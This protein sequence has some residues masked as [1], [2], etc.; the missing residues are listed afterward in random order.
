MQSNRRSRTAEATAAMRA[1]H[2]WFDD[3]PRVL[4]DEYADLLLS[5]FGFASAFPLARRLALRSLQRQAAWLLA[6]QGRRLPIGAR[7]MRAQVLTRSR[8]AEDVL[9]ERLAEGTG[10]FVLLGAGLDT[11]ALRRRD[12]A[13]RVRVFEVD[14]PETQRFKRERVERLRDGSPDHL[15]FVPCDFERQTLEEAL[16]PSSYDPG[17]PAVFS[18]LGVTYYLSVE[19]IRATFDFFAGQAAGGRLVLDYWNELAVPPLDA[20]LLEVVRASVSAQGEPMLSFFTRD[21]IAAEATN[22][23]LRVLENLSAD[24]VNRRYL[25]GRRD[26]LV[27][28]GFGR[29]LALGNGRDD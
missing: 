28:P 24:D 15:E 17:R 26:G 3:E 1:I 7:R 20:S 10:Q 14:H 2:Q 11:F 9:L 16:S 25:E 18:W 13:D 8:Y 27:V 19:A 29:L 23:G 21:R 5:P 22:S 12:L 4:D 6:V